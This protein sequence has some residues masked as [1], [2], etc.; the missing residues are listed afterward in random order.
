MT[1]EVEM[2]RLPADVYAGILFSLLGGGFYI[3]A[4]D[5]TPEAAVFP[6]LTIGTFIILSIAMTIES[7]VNL[8]NNK[9]AK[10]QL[11]FKEIKIP[12]IVFIFIT[13]YVTAMKYLGFCLATI[14]FIPGIALFYGNRQIF[15]IITT[16][17]CLVGF[18]YLLFVVQLKLALP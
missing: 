15:H 8:K 12:L 5:L 1:G 17:V 18:I 10:Q 2:K 9:R 6:K 13:V 7:L 11:T 14:A 3:L 16:T 4:Q